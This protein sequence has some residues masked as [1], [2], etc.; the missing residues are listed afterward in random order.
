MKRDVLK[1]K[2]SDNFF[3][4]FFILPYSAGK[5]CQRALADKSGLITN[6]TE[7]MGLLP[8]AAASKTF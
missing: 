8:A 4:V 2:F 7:A 1:A 6:C 5:D 3:A